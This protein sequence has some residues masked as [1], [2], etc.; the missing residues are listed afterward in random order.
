MN[1]LLLTKLLDQQGIKNFTERL[2][3]HH[4]IHSL[5]LKAEPLEDQI[6]QSMCDNAETKGLSSAIEWLGGSHK[7]NIDI[8][9][10]DKENSDLSI[11]S[12]SLKNKDTITAISGGRLQKIF[13][14]EKNT[15]VAT[16]WEIGGN[17]V[18]NYLNSNSNHTILCAPSKIKKQN[19]KIKSISYKLKYITGN[20]FK[21]P[22]AEKWT[23]NGGV[24][25]VTLDSGI[26]AYI[27]TTLSCQ[28][29]WDIPTS[30]FN[31]VADIILTE[32]NICNF[33]YQNRTEIDEK[34]I[35]S[36]NM[37]LFE[38]YKN[39]NLNYSLYNYL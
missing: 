37:D 20:F 11:K 14:S 30:L 9:F 23:I 31:L 3:H 2:Q 22:S 15:D 17:N 28:L 8:E 39:I 18:V 1:N 10:T 7:Q 13:G 26:K 27:K 19:K 4:Q 6:Y 34:N 29:W 25:S 32:D 16:L 12:G 38:F 35:T 21:Y 24:I 5:A 36:L 33:K